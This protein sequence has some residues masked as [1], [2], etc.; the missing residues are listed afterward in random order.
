MNLMRFFGKT[1]KPLIMLQIKIATGQ[2]DFQIFAGPNFLEE[3]FERLP[4]MLVAP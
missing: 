3:V 1:P 2:P 4:D